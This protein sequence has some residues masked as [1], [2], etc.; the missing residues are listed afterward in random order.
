G[1]RFV[2]LAGA[3]LDEAALFLVRGVVSCRHESLLAHEAAGG[4][5]SCVD[6]VTVAPRRVASGAIGCGSVKAGTLA[7]A[8]D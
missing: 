5:R 3:G 4:E 7:G 1:A 6:S 2:L 8:H